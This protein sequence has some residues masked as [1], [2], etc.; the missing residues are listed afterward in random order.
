[1]IVENIHE[2]TNVDVLQDQVRK[3][4]ANLTV[5]FESVE[6]VGRTA[7]IKMSS[8][9]TALGARLRLGRSKWYEGCTFRWGEDECEGDLGELRMRWEREIK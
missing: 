1:M 4:S 8:I 5:E 7:V 2:G 3:Q 6:I 9:G